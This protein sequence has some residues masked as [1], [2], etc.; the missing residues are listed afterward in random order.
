MAIEFING[1]PL[2]DPHEVDPEARGSGKRG[3]L[4]RHF[5]F[6]VQQD[7]PN[8]H[9]PP[10]TLARVIQQITSIFNAKAEKPA[11]APGNRSAVV[12]FRTREGDRHRPRGRWGAA[13][14][15]QYGNHQ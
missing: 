15:F 10:I 9:K 12:T 3:R 2:R 5:S 11:R 7:S 6:F 4:E 1:F 14:W 13:W 8:R